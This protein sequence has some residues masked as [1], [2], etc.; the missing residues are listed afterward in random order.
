MDEQWVIA[1]NVKMLR[2]EAK[3]SVCGLAKRAGISHSTIS[4]IEQ[5]DSM[6]QPAT[7]EKLAAALDISLDEFYR[8]R[9][10]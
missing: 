2:A 9:F 5:R 7:I 1:R 8:P 10:V 4:A 6:P 3:L